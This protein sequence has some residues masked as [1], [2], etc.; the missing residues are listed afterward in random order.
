MKHRIIRVLNNPWLIICHFVRRFSFLISDKL[1]LSIYFRTYLGSWINW[2]NPLSFCEKLQWLKLYDRN[3]EYIKMVDK[4]AVKDYVA[5]KIGSEYIIPTISY[6]SSPENINWDILPQ[7]FVLKS[8]HGGGGTGVII[9]SNKAEFNKELAYLKLKESYKIDIYKS[10]KEWPYKGVIKRILAEELLVSDDGDLKDYKVFCFN[11]EPRLIQLHSGRFTENHTSKFYDTHW[12]RLSISQSSIYELDNDIV[13]EPV[14]LE[15][16]LKFSR[17]LAKDIPHV[18]ID[19][20]C[21]NGKLYFGEITFFDG[22]GFSPFD[23][24]QDELTIGSWIDLELS[25]SRKQIN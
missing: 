1:F 5:T 18:R 3:P 25:Y 22:S 16:M 4:L 19:W 10:L 20:Y 17:I 12:N 21:C 23:K 11:G 9:C 15:E 14:C 6:W 2:N 13:P 7:K 8:T 24:I